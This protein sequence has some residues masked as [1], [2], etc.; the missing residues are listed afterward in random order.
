MAVT[1]VAANLVWQQAKIALAAQNS[2]VGIPQI[3]RNQFDALKAHLS[4][5][6]GNPD[7]KFVPFLATDVDDA[8]GSILADAACK[9]YGAF[10]FKLNTATDVFLTFLDDATDDSLAAATTL[11]TVLP[12]TSGNDVAAVFYPMGL[13]MANGVVAKAWTEFDG[14]TDSSSADTPNGFIIIGAP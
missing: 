9:L 14:T 13:P 8:S 3:I 11:V 5:T 7:L 2:T 4:Q 1:P 10:A 6:K 12:L